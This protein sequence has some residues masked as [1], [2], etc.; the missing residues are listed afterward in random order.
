MAVLFD[1]IST[2]EEV[3]K[4]VET[5]ILLLLCLLCA[6]FKSLLSILQFTVKCSDYCNFCT[7]L[8]NTVLLQTT[9]TT[10]LISIKGV[11]R[12]FLRFGLFYVL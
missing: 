2:A 11:K 12:H 3:L 9:D 5:T 7:I 10:K 8:Q 1:T 4:I 6:F